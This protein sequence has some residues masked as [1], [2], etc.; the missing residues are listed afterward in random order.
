MGR[1]E[2]MAGELRGL[3]DLDGDEASFSEVLGETLEPKL[4]FGGLDVG[5][6]NSDC[7]AFSW[8]QSGLSAV[9][10]SVVR[11]E[12]SPSLDLPGDFT[13]QEHI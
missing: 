1:S 2:E 12:V 3:V 8:Y 10:I 5:P 4:E 9:L 7:F 6:F 11:P 13:A